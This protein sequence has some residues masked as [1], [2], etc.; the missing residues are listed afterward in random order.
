MKITIINGSP[1]RKGATGK[2]LQ[3][4]KKRLEEK[5]NVEICYINLSDYELLSCLG[6]EKCYKTGVCHIKDK[7]EEINYIIASSQGVIIGSPTYVSNVSGILKNYIDRGHIV[8]EQ[9]FE[10]KYMFAITTYEIAGGTNV[11]SML[12]TMF[13]YAGGIPAGKYSLKL[14]HN[15][16]PFKHARVLK[17]IHKKADKFYQK[18]N[19]AKRKSLFNR[20]VNFIVLHV[21]IKPSVVRYPERYHAVLQRWKNINVIP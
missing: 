10:G 2:I 17:Q 15:S 20:L 9:A 7:A 16:N 21:V 6:C 19:Q 12:K 18:I 4:F 14:N 13:R 1:R 3:A 5:A 11:I 8:V